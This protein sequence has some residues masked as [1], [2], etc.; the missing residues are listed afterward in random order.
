MKNAERWSYIRAELEVIS[1][2]GV[3][4]CDLSTDSSRYHESGHLIAAAP[5]MYNELVDAK[6]AFESI[7]ENYLVNAIYLSAL[8]EQIESITALL[9]KARGEK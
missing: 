4:V 8:H 7:A 5:E 9:A 2:T 1:Q 3:S 6:A